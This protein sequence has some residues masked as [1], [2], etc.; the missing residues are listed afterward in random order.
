LIR[1]RANVARDAEYF[2]DDDDAAARLAGG[3]REISVEALAVA[4]GEFNI[5]AHGLTLQF[6]RE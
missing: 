5:L 1:N 3:W 2:L 4:R 6:A